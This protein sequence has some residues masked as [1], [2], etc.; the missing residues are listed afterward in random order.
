MLRVNRIRNQTPQVEERRGNVDG[1][2]LAHM[3]LHN[4]S[5]PRGTQ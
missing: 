3:A 2:I 4:V 1:Q 5:V